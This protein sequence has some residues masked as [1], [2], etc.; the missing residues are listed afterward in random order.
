MALG[1]YVHTHWSYRHPYAASTWSPD[2][3]RGYLTGLRALGYDQLMFWPLCDAMPAQLTAS[4]RALLAR[5]AHAIAIAQR[6]LGMRFILTLGANVIGN[7]RAREYSYEERPYFYCERK[8]NPADPDA[9]G[10]FLT[11][12]RRQLEP[13]AAADGLAIIDSDPGGY[14]GSND[15]EFVGLLAA[16]IGLFREFNP[17]AELIYWMWVGWEAYNRFWAE[18]QQGSAEPSLRIEQASFERA[19]TGLR[20]RIAEPWSVFAAFPEHLAATRALGLVDKR[21]YIAYGAIEGEPTFPLIN[22]QPTAIG[23][24]LQRYPDEPFPRGAMGNA[25][26]HCLQL[27]GLYLFAHSAKGGTEDSVDLDAFAEG[28][29]PGLGDCIAAAWRTLEG[30][31]SPA[32]REAARMVRAASGQQRGLGRYA[33]LLFGSPERFLEDLALN[34]HVRAALADFGQ[35]VA[36]GPRTSVAT[37]L[38]NVLDELVPYQQRLGFADAYGGPLYSLLN[39][40]LAR[41][42]DPGIDAILAQFH[43]WRSPAVR[44]GVLSRLFATLETR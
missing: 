42:H 25:Q 33:G 21:Q 38:R 5:T 27:P 1:M 18:A 35:A 11:A 29:L 4:D 8:V 31:S 39:E 13:L 44:H 34:L 17:R 19:L 30:G 7:D 3:W 23:A 20:A 2:D 28:L 14:V 43:D 41:L 36:C 10:A 6:E 16:Q 40:P 15:E 24:A 12:R 37:A 9:L 26:T 22:C 32:Q